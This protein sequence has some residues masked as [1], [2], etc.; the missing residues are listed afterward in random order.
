MSGRTAGNVVDTRNEDYRAKLGLTPEQQAYDTEWL[1]LASVY[2]G[3][4]RRPWLVLGLKHS[5]VLVRHRRIETYVPQPLTGEKRYLY[6]EELDIVL[7]SDIPAKAV[8]RGSR[9][10][11]FNVQLLHGHTDAAGRP[12][13]GGNDAFCLRQLDFAKPPIQSHPMFHDALQLAGQPTEQAKGE[14]LL[15]PRAGKFRI[16][17]TD[18]WVDLCVGMPLDSEEPCVVYRIP[19]TSQTLAQLELHNLDQPVAKDALLA[20][21][22]E[23]LTV[24]IA[25]L[26]GAGN[27]FI[28]LVGNDVLSANRGVELFRLLN[29]MHKLSSDMTLL[30]GKDRPQ[31][32]P[33]EDWLPRVQFVL[34]ADVQPKLKN[35]AV[36]TKLFHELG[37]R[38]SFGILSPIVGRVQELVDVPGQPHLKDLLILPNWVGYDT[39]EPHRLRVPATAVLRVE[40]GVQVSVG[41]HVADYCKRIAFTDWATV[42]GVIGEEVALMVL[43]DF[44]KWLT[45]R[46]GRLGWEGPHNL[47]PLE[48]LAEI[49]RGARWVWDIGPSL[50]YLTPEGTI[51]GPAIKQNEWTDFTFGGPST[52]VFDASPAFAKLRSQQ[53]HQP[54]PAARKG[55]KQRHRGPREK[56][57]NDSQ[58]S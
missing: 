36:H 19:R 53:S 2:S 29:R 52:A 3:E 57:P 14:R 28:D 35:E 27:P 18:R 44:V 45:T 1:R 21:L 12:C 39:E 8:M 50:P 7:M 33:A 6:P 38:G 58:T 9:H 23:P 55:K 5:P 17:E 56:Q 43:D 13:V 49:P 4:V 37:P 26:D 42:E 51:C 48:V 40:P 20:V 10:V 30:T 24:H 25:K 32:V 34:P 47:W 41:E 46:P 16:V 11:R 54:Q 15:A 22:L 31:V